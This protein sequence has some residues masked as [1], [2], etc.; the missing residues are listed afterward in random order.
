MNQKTVNRMTTLW[1]TC[2]ASC[3]ILLGREV[4]VAQVSMVVGWGDKTYGQTSVPI[5]AFNATNISAGGYH[6]LALGDDGS[7][8]AWGRGTEG[9]TNVPV[10]LGNVVAIAGGGFHSLALQ[11]DGTV[12]AWGAGSSNYTG[13][14]NFGQAI[15]PRGL[16]NV[17]AIAA[18]LQHSVALK[19]SG[20]VVAWGDNSFGQTNVPAGL[21]NVVAIAAAEGY[22]S[23]ALRNDGTVVAWGWNNHGQTNVPPGLTNVE[24]PDPYA[25][26]HPYPGPPYFSSLHTIAVGAYH[27]L[28]LKNDGTIAAWGT[29]VLGAATVPGG[30]ANVYNIA[31]GSNFSL[32]ITANGTVS[33][34]GDNTYGQI[35]VP[36]GLS[37]VVAI[38]GGFRHS[39]ALHSCLP[40]IQTLS[41]TRSLQPDGIL[42]TFCAAYQGDPPLY[43]AW[44]TNYNYTPASYS[45]GCFPWLVSATDDTE[46]GPWGGSPYLLLC[47]TNPCGRDFVGAFPTTCAICLSRGRPNL[48][49][50]TNGSGSGPALYTTNCGTLSPYAK[51]FKLNATNET[52]WVTVSTEGSSNQPVLAVYTGPITD[53]TQLIR[54][55]CNNSTSTHASR[56]TF[57]AI[58]GTSYWIIVDPGTVY[59]TVRLASGFEPQ[60]TNYSV[61]KS[62]R[63]FEMYSTVAPAITY[64]LQATTNPGSASSWTSLL[65]T[66]YTTN[67]QIYFRDT[68]APNFKQ[69]FYRL[70]AP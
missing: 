49:T 13:I 46:N 55:A 54:V 40:L 18:G 62:N 43:I 8:V 52:G 28:A 32:A 39:L 1:G 60:L 24:V 51:W 44:E 66:N 42:L 26:Y 37:S 48:L 35:S 47:L 50:S 14:Y 64:R 69:R 53:P 30:L 38:A 70:A 31:A 61:N 12:V 67:Y 23:M 25:L 41:L 58:K 45:S 19:S 9:Q 5:M 11:G 68:N 2:V 3:L 21:S 33:A 17:T 22:H 65:T 56:V 7:V 16:S 15:V 6:S 10:G 57:S 34:W 59:P 36:G 63:A 4:G 27:A 29:N 20:T